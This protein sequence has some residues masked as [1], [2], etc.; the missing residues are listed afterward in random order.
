M[1]VRWLRTALRN[2]EEEA[3]YIAADNPHMASVV[4]QRILAATELLRTQAALGRPGRVAGT[5]ELI[6]ANTPY[7]IP[8]RIRDDTVEILRV[9]HSS[10][11]P[12]Q[13]W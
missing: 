4:M 9:F 11:R 12:P 1:H 13:K 8:Y 10:R 2:L 7:L 3:N 6:V 5:R